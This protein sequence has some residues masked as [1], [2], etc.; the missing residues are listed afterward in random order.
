MLDQPHVFT[1][2]TPVRIGARHARG[3]FMSCSD[4]QDAIRSI[5]RLRHEIN[6]LIREQLDA[7]QSATFSGIN[8]PEAE[9]CDTRRE[10][11]RKLIEELWQ[12]RAAIY[13]FNVLHQQ[14]RKYCLDSWHGRL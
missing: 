3:L 2:C 9:Q 6:K 13:N 4:P 5:E 12:R 8:S 10:A 11:V 14:A 7:Y 1:R